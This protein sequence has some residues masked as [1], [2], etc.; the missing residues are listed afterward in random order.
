MGAHFLEVLKGAFMKL[1]MYALLNGR[2]MMN[3]HFS[4]HLSFCAVDE[5]AS[6]VSVVLG[7]RD[8]NADA[9]YFLQ[10]WTAHFPVHEVEENAHALVPTIDEEI[11]KRMA[12]GWLVKQP[13][14]LLMSPDAGVVKTVAKRL[15]AAF[16]SFFLNN[17][18]DDQ[19]VTI[20]TEPDQ[21]FAVWVLLAD[22]LT[23]H[24]SKGIGALVPDLRKP[25]Q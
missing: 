17:A 4:L 22:H 25:V 18:F 2:D 7:F 12:Q 1:P 16:D 15:K 24:F 23:W 20:E 10:H 19:L 8:A 6:F 3:D 11:V 14:E 21:S 9:D 5:K 13:T